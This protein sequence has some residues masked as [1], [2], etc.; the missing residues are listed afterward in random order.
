L[1][2]GGFQAHQTILQFLLLLF[3]SSFPSSPPS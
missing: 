3:V 2:L 1:L